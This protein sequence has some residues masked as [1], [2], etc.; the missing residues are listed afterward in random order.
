[1]TIP[2]TEFGPE[3]I[4]PHSWRSASASQSQSLKASVGDVIPASFIEM[5]SSIVRAEEDQSSDPVVGCGD[6]DNQIVGTTAPRKDGSHPACREQMIDNARSVYIPIRLS[7]GV[8]V[9]VRPSVFVH[10]PLVL[11]DIN[12]DV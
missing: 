8:V 3:S 7:C 12:S 1:V 11:I 10:S 5:M 9:C 4:L 2:H 6:S